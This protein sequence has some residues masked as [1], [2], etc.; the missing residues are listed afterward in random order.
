MTKYYAGLERVSPFFDTVLS[1][2][3][4]CKTNKVE[5][6]HI[7]SVSNWQDLI[8]KQN[9][10]IDKIHYCRQCYRNMLPGEP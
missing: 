3:E 5:Y 1:C 6:S 8:D 4:W 7:I 9:N 2:Q 10:P